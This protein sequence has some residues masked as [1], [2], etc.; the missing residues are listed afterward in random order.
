MDLLFTHVCRKYDSSKPIEQVVSE[1]VDSHSIGI[2]NF[3]TTADGSKVK[4][5][6]AFF[7]KVFHP[8]AATVKLNDLIRFHIHVCNDK[9]IH[10]YHL[11]IRLFN[12]ENDAPWII[13]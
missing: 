12:L 9:S 10:V 8:A 11:A 7:N 6:F 5:I 3:G 4:A 2:D 1:H 13:P